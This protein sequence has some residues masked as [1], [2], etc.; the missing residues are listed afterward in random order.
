MP[1]A[2]NP[3]FFLERSAARLHSGCRSVA[4]RLPLLAGACSYPAPG[5]PYRC[6]P[7]CRARSGRRSGRASWPHPQ[8]HRGG[9]ARD[10]R[11][12]PGHCIDGWRRPAAGARRLRPG[13]LV[14][15]Y[16]FPVPQLAD[17]I[18]PASLLLVGVVLVVD[19]ARRVVKNPL[20]RALAARYAGGTLRLAKVTRGRV[21]VS[22]GHLVAHL[23]EL[24][25]CRA[26]SSE[27][28]TVA[29]GRRGRAR[30]RGRAGACCRLRLG[31]T[32]TAS[33]PRNRA[34]CQHHCRVLGGARVVSLACEAPRNGG[35]VGLAENGST[36]PDVRPAG[37][38]AARRHKR[39]HSCRNTRSVL[40]SS[41]GSP[42]SGL[43]LMSGTG[44]SA[45]RSVRPVSRKK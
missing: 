19:G 23:D 44:P 22:A 13:P 35:A 43:S 14:K 42:L 21:L 2:S 34:P 16:L 4:V 29:Y 1:Q 41:S 15:E 9:G 31:R 7:R 37:Q 5:T 27:R 24:E 10:S 30:L 17:F 32:L 11:L 38:V 40:P 20:V 6:G 39:A 26:Y 25:A 33:E 3:F 45:S 28:W 8:E 12:G 18:G 36:A